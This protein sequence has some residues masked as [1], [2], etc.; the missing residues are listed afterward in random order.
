MNPQEADSF[1]GEAPAKTFS[2]DDANQFLGPISVPGVGKYVPKMPSP[3]QDTFLASTGIGRVLNQVGQ[4][5]KQAWG[6]E[7]LGLSPGTTEALRKAGIFNDVAKGQFSL[8]RAANEA[9]MRPAAAALDAAQRGIGAVFGGAEEGLKQTGAELGVPQV[10]QTAAEMVEFE[11]IGRPGVAHS[12]VPVD[13]AAAQNM[14]AIGQ[15]E[16]AYMGTAEPVTPAP[17]AAVKANVQTE[18]TGEPVAPEPSPQ[19]PAARTAAPETGTAQTVTPFV[20][21]S[22]FPAQTSK[23]GPIFPAHFSPAPAPTDVHGYAR[24]LAPDT[25]NEYDALAAHQDTLRQ[26]IA[27]AQAELQKGFEDQAPHAAEIADLEARMQDTTPRLAKKYQS[28]LDAMTAERDA[29]LAD[30]DG[31]ALVTR[32]TPEIMAMR[33]QLLETDFRMRDLAPDVAGAYRRAADLMPPVEEPEIETPPAAEQMPAPEEDVSPQT[34]QAEEIG[35]ETQTEPAETQPPQA[36]KAPEEIGA[37]GPSPQTPAPIPDI[38]AD[39]SQKLQAAGRPREEADASG[40]VS[41]ALWETRAAAF[42]GKKGTAE[43]MYAREAPDIRAGKPAARQLELAQ[44]KGGAAGK[45]RLATDGRAVITLMKNADA[46]TFLHETGHDWLERMMGDA[47]DPDAPAAMR[48]DA[49][50]V[51]KYLGVGDDEALTTRAHEKFARSF[52]RYF[53]EGRAPSKALAG[54]FAKFKDWLT[55]IYQTVSKLRAPITP[56]IRD[57]FDRLLAKNP[58]RQPAIVVDEA[59]GPAP[60]NVVPP[61]QPTPIE[62]TSHLATL[63]EADLAHTEPEVAGEVASQVRREIDRAATTSVPEAGERIAATRTGSDQPGSRDGGSEP[64]GG[65]ADADGAGAG[66]DPGAKGDVSKPGA[67]VQGRGGP[68]EQGNRPQAEPAGPEQPFARSDDGLIDK[69]GN[70][71]LD[72]LNQPEDVNTVIREAAEAS[73]DHIEARRGVISDQHVLDLADALG[74]QPS[75]LNARKLGQAFNAEQVMAARK[76]LIQSAQSVR[77]AMAK[78]AN[79]SDADVMVYAEARARH[80]MIQDQVAGITAEAGRALRAFRSIGEEGAQTKALGDFLQGATGKTL[81]QLRREA[82]AGMLL[83]TPQ[84]VSKF[85]RDSA[86]PTFGDMALEYWINGLISGPAT[87]TTYA[88]GNSLLA[89]WKAVPETAVA[90]AIGKLRGGDA[91]VYAGEVNAQVYGLMKGQRDGVRA[92]W[93]AAKTGLTAELPGEGEAGAQTSMLAMQGPQGAIPG[94]LGAVIR[95][96]SRGVAT[97]H[98]YFRAIGYSQGIAQLAYRQAAKEGLD[99]QAFAARVA[100]LTTNPPAEMMEQ[101]RLGAT[102]QTLMNQGGDLTRKVSDLFDHRFA[103]AGGFPLLKLIDPFVKIGANVMSQALME[104][105]PLGVLNADIRANLMGRNGP[106]ARDTQIARIGVGSALGATVIGMASQGLITGGGPSDP[107]EAAVW[108]LAGNQPYSVKIGQ[109][110]YAYHRLGPLG[111]ILGVAADMHEVGSAMTDHDAGHVATLVTTSL[112][113]SLLDESF[114]RGPSELLQAIEDSDRYGARYVR[115]QLATLIPFSTGMAQMARAAD[116]YAREAR[117]TLDAIRARVPFL[118]QSLFPRR[119]LFGN[120]LPNTDALGAAGLT[121]IMETR[122]KN[123]PVTAA[124]LRV[125]YYPTP[126]KPDINGV[127]LTDQQY[128]DYSRI[129]GR[130]AKMRLD[131]LVNTPGFASLPNGVQASTM[132]NIMEHS[133]RAAATMV[134]MQNPQVIQQAMENKRIIALQGRAALSH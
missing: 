85:T 35:P 67:V 49:A 70:I 63:H 23:L 24:S 75:D 54:V 115:N 8:V 80:L 62:V 44:T 15:P 4:G 25:F 30:E 76:L 16:A 11:G 109:T 6:T 31:R 46:S 38:A 26:Q 52:E 133:R 53:M 131:A 97:I 1:L 29:F 98:S 58:E 28:R 90:A 110:W 74:M 108:R 21:E 72:N 121:S 94:K 65:G 81:F 56:D 40:Q 42:E 55:T 119:D 18:A 9:V 106:I 89:L 5:A 111:M 36:E 132:Q 116:P 47:K 10:G 126:P 99:G 7:D 27:D 88:I 68:T 61:R 118:S 96:P 41:K 17:E 39:V 12:P 78:A 59:E 50:T 130:M 86:K 71:R 125:G 66:G 64:P 95:L 120:P 60:A 112:A 103:S 101:A 3:E 22:P 92:A 69:A 102:D 83:D 82:K 19:A 91:R 84:Q 37:A 34:P 113:K 128:D 79:G 57:V 33:Q 117:T 43:E 51:R 129:G 13:L 122:A 73:G 77:D 100:D 48:T 114:M 127:R 2:A 45:I 93:K 14:H 32:D 123:D 134:Q 20:P 87:H 124:M 105:S 104:R 107:K